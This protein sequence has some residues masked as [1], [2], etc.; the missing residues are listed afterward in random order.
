[1]VIDPQFINEQFIINLLKGEVKRLALNSEDRGKLYDFI[2]EECVRDREFCL[3]LMVL[4]CEICQLVE[5]ANGVK[6]GKKCECKG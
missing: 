2:V 6:E 1:M 3:S 4:A 5:V